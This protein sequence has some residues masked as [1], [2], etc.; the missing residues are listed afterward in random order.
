MNSN[1]L[2]LTS[3]SLRNGEAL[4]LQRALG[5]RIEALVGR[6][7]ITMDGDLRDIVLDAGEGFTVDRATGVLIS[8]IS[9]A[10]FVVLRS[11]AVTAA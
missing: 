2:K 11:T 3:T 4:H 9:D 5:Q 7:W 6:V 10:Q 1:D 8:A